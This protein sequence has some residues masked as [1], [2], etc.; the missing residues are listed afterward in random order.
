M[1]IA[2]GPQCSGCRLSRIGSELL[3]E[4][5]RWRCD[6]FPQGLPDVYDDGEEDCPYREPQS[7]DTWK[8]TGIEGT[9]LSEA[10]ED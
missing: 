2:M 9:V 10:D 4:D 7:Q 8:P 6:P 5:I 3:G 1:Q